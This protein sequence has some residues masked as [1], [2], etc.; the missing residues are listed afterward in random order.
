MSLFM[1]L[2][3]VIPRRLLSR[4]VGKLMHLK[5]PFRLNRLTVKLFADFY[6]INVDE[7]EYPI[8]YYSSIGDFFVRRLKPEARPVSEAMLVHPADAKISQAAMIESGELIQAKNKTYSLRSFLGADD[9][10]N[11]LKNPFFITYYLCPTDYHRVHCPADARVLS[12]HYLPGDLWPVN[13]WST[14]RIES[15]F[16]VNERVVIELEIASKKAFAVLVGATNVGKMTLAFDSDLIT[17]QGRRGSPVFKT[18]EDVIL[19]KNDELGCF[20]M[21]STVVMVYDESFLG[22]LSKLKSTSSRV[23]AALFS[24]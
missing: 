22:D 20:H 10:V 6:N 9:Y 5:L 21:G 19:K 14:T 18:Y 2:L 15:L 12:V 17:N 16:S 1:Y 8:G 23:G 24:E 3:Y 4:I 11:S 7:A 13:E